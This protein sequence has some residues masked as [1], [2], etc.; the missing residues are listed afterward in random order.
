MPVKGSLAGTKVGR[1]SLRGWKVPLLK[2]AQGLLPVRA[3]LPSVSTAFA[4][5]GCKHVHFVF[6]FLTNTL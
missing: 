5:T 1:E 4:F 3:T 2:A 6:S